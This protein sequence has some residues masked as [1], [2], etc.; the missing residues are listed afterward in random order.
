MPS[1]ECIV[2]VFIDILTKL[3]HYLIC[4]SD[5]FQLRKEKIELITILPLSQFH[6]LKELAD[7]FPEQG[8]GEKEE[9]IIILLKSNISKWNYGRLDS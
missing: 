8:Y 9:K 6:P 4:E 7:P 3:Q 5:L 1:T 2:N